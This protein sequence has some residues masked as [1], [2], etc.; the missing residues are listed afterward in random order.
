VVGSNPKGVAVNASTNRIYVEN[1]GYP[2]AVSVID[3]ASNTVVASVVLGVDPKDVAVNASTNRIYVTNPG[4][5][6][7]SVIQDYPLPGAVGGVAEAPDVAER[8]GKSP[9]SLPYAIAGA[10]AVVLVL[11]AGGWYAGR[12][13]QR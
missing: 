12:R 2:G 3:G 13:W 6:T 7:V 1:A 5:D 10:A 9:S 8:A 4:D 11:A